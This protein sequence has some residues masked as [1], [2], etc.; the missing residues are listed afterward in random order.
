MSRKYGMKKYVMKWIIIIAVFLAALVIISGIMNKGNT[1]M[2]AQMAEASFPVVTMKYEGRS[3]NVLHGYAEAMDVS[4]MRESITP[5]ESGRR[6]SIEVD[7]G[8]EITGLQFEVR[9]IDGGRLIEST[10]LQDYTKEGDKITASFALKDLI[11]NNKEYMLVLIL[12]T[13]EGTD[14]RY[15]TRVIYA[16]EYYAAEKLD[17]VLDFSEKTFD[18]EEAKELTRYLESNSEGDNTTLGTVN[19]HSSFSQVTWGDLAVKRVGEPSVTIR[20]LAS[21]TGSFLLQYYVSSGSGKN[22]VYYEVEEFFRVRYTAE[23]MYLL[24]YERTMNQVFDDETDVYT[25]NKIYL[26]ITGDEIPLMESDG[27]SIAVF[28]TNN[29]LYSY[30]VVDQKLSY[31]FG[32]YRQD[33]AD[34][35][36]LYD[37]HQIKILSV[38]EGGNVTFM[39]Y[40]YMN[41]GRHE[42]ETGISVYYYDGSVNTTEELLYIPYDKS[43]ELLMAEV[44]QLTYLNRQGTLYL[45]LNNEIYGINVMDRTWEA[46]AKD[47]KEGTYQIS[48]SNRMI[49]WQKENQLYQS[50]TLILMNLT[51]GEQSSI[52]AGSGEAIAPVG[53]MEDD[54]IYGI[55]KK[56]DI[57]PDYAG[58]TLFPMYTVKIQNEAEGILKEYEQENVYITEG[59]VEGNQ[60]SLKRLKKSED[61]SYEEIADDHIMNAGES[62]KTQNYVETVAIDVYEKVTQIALKE[63]IDTA[64]MKLLTPREVLFEGSRSV[65][66]SDE[67]D[68]AGR[69]YVYGKQGIEGIFMDEGNAVN[70]ADSV[71]GVVVDD[72][73]RYV[74]MRGNRSLKN[75]IMAIKETSLTEGKTA[76][77]LCLETMLS[78]EGI[79]RNAQYLLDSGESVIKILQENLEEVTV[80][81]LSG[82]SLDSV[83]YYVNQDIP[84][85]A[86]LK[87]GTAVLV[88]GFNEKNTVIMNPTDGT[89]AKMGMNDSKEWFE[90]N[91]N[92]FITYIRNE[93]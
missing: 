36:T 25:G 14:I 71:S 86:M 74:W 85:L 57:V 51:T 37:K 18:K 11:E 84:V 92:R 73:G 41:R 50:T 77:A 55:A 3:I 80:L 24:D 65:D 42:G 88:V 75:Q 20:E 68:A 9:S 53:F 2:T 21:Q 40:G 4:Y 6:T 61:G 47:L 32:F 70:L 15:Y 23:R 49:V 69:Y 16:Q 13:E 48:D 78:Y 91:G 26:G 17:Y 28:I 45:M 59:N 76:L 27:G 58:N 93:E 7:F 54:L 12:T 79:S 29:R 52:R 90:E 39:V 66:I 31:L 81:D 62:E 44:E 22:I 83:L 67:E 8:G 33:N 38:D 87:D 10:G 43:P 5:L 34:A 89:L 82:C 64:A 30:N 56:S 46:V 60:I 72:D 35:R 63:E 19:I 1:D